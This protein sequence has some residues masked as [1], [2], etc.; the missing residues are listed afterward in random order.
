M[1]KG[2]QGDS[3]KAKCVWR[4]H[5]ETCYFIVYLKM[6]SL[7]CSATCMLFRWEDSLFCESML[8]FQ[9][10]PDNGQ[11]P[12]CP[13]TLTL[14][15]SGSSTDFL[16]PLWE[17]L[18]L[19]PLL[20]SSTFFPRAHRPLRLCIRSSWFSRWLSYN[21]QHIFIIPSEYHT[22]AFFENSFWKWGAWEIAP[23]ERTLLLCQRI[24]VWVPASTSHKCLQL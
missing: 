22:L 10:T 18:A 3:M 23:W 5:K 21:F 12:S 8:E 11:G 2:I 1:R 9:S 13:E 17:T 7:Y 24:G 4:C 6:C 16:P 15:P 20:C 14:C 19:Y